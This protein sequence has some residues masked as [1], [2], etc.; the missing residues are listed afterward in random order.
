[1][2]GKRWNHIV[3]AIGWLWSLNVIA[4]LGQWVVVPSTRNSPPE[5]D[6]FEFRAAST[7]STAIQGA[8]CSA[9]ASPWIELN[10]SSFRLGDWIGAWVEANK[11]V[12]PRT[13]YIQVNPSFTSAAQ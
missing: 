2:S 11:T 5:G 6:F 13:G 7:A 10:A 4:E 9:S 8:E 12:Y 1:M 3:F